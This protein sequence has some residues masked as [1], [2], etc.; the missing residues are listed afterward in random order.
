MCPAKVNFQGSSIPFTLKTR[1]SYF[2]SEREDNEL[3]HAPKIRHP[4]CPLTITGVYGSRWLECEFSRIP[5]RKSICTH[6]IGPDFLCRLSPA[7]TSRFR[8]AR[9]T[10][11]FRCH[12]PDDWPMPRRERLLPASAP[13]AEFSRP[14]SVP[15]FPDDGVSPDPTTAGHHF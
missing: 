13:P 14:P 2:Q 4:M 1:F 7:T 12:R 5:A 6:C 9:E 10:R 8:N 11:R 15:R 3:L